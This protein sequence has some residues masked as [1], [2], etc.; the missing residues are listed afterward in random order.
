MRKLQARLRKTLPKPSVGNQLNYLASPQRS[1]I[2]CAFKNAAQ[3]S[4]VGFQLPLEF[5][6]VPHAGKERERAKLNNSQPHQLLPK[7]RRGP[8]KTMV[9]AH[10][11]IAHSRWGRLTYGDMTWSRHRKFYVVVV[12]LAMVAWGGGMVVVRAADSP[13]TAA[14]RAKAESGDAEAQCN[15]G[16]RYLHGREGVEMDEA[17][18]LVWLQKA[19]AQSHP[20]AF[21]YLGYMH[22]TGK[23]LTKNTTEAVKHYRKSVDLGNLLAAVKLGD[24]YMAE[25]NA[26]K[27]A[28][29]YT[30]AAAKGDYQAQGSLG[31]MYMTGRGVEKDPAFAYSWLMLATLHTSGQKFTEDLHRL[32]PTLTQEQVIEGMQLMT[33]FKAQSTAS[34][35]PA[36]VARQQHQNQIKSTPAF[37]PGQS[38]EHQMLTIDRVTWKNSSSPSDQT[39]VTAALHTAEWFDDQG[40]DQYRRFLEK[41]DR[42]FVL[43]ATGRSDIPATVLGTISTSEMIVNGKHTRDRSISL[44]IERGNHARMAP[45]V[46]Y[47]L[48]PLNASDAAQWAVKPGVTLTA[49]KN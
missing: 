5:V 34:A 29:W 15:L 14:M 40:Q 36:D 7:S 17:A 19:A 39:H 2:I 18:A 31:Q 12:T 11:R 8:L 49:A 4:A 48:V 10:F 9:L 37:V 21:A 22:Q 3:S 25:G 30:Y 6:G 23:G 26:A 16:V 41:A 42:N 45:G 20:G 13:G 38:G 27:A 28:E 44:E 24:L 1:P 32:I 43:R 33:D 46:P 35:S 47:K